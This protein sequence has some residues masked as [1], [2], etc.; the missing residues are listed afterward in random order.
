MGRRRTHVSADTDRVQRLRVRDRENSATSE[1]PG[2]GVLQIL[3]YVAGKDH[4]LH[5]HRFYVVRLRPTH[6]VPFAVPCAEMQ[7]PGV[8]SVR[9]VSG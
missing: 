1:G 7:V 9:L 5:T 2:S 6:A 4:G 3:R 8:R